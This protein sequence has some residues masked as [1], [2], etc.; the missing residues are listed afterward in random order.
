ME[1]M[2]FPELFN[3]SVNE[4]EGREGSSAAQPTFSGEG[5]LPLMPFNISKEDNDGISFG[6][7]EVLP[8]PSLPGPDSFF[9]LLEPVPVDPTML[10]EGDE[11]QSTMPDTPA[12][13]D[14]D[15]PF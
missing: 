11:P 2:T 6:Q 4:A 5:L 12:S 14:V 1:A 13:P 10:L 8:R 9:N 15:L 3:A 7:G